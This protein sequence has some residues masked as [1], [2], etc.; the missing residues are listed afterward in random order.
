[1]KW[2]VFAV[3]ILCLSLS[4]VPGFANAQTELVPSDP[5]VLQNNPPDPTLSSVNPIADNSKMNIIHD[6][7][8]GI[9]ADQAS[10]RP[11]DL[12]IT[13]HIRRNIVKN[14]NLS[15][16]GHNVKIITRDG[17]VV[18][19]GPV[20]SLNEKQTIEDTAISVV[21]ARNVKS[22]LEVTAR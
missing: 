22:E 21:G 15:L 3:A 12:E 2:V 4:L 10:N 19:K 1:M 13:R 11:E 16:Y 18:L 6:G 17:E 7:K 8:L 14:K 9:S 5:T 20:R